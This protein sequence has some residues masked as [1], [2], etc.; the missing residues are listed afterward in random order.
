MSAGTKIRCAAVSVGLVLA[1]SVPSTAGATFPGRNGDI[2]FGLS[3][4]VK[5]PM[6]E[7]CDF[8]CMDTRIYAL[9]PQRQKVRRVPTCA[10]R[11]CDDTSPS[12]SRSG[13]YIVFERRRY[14]PSGTFDELLATANRNGTDVQTIEGGGRVPSWAPSGSR[15]AY[16]ARPAPDASSEVYIYDEREGTARRLTFGKGASPDWSAKGRIAFTRP[17]FRKGGFTGRYGLY[18]V[19]PNGRGRRLI[20]GVGTPVQPNW[21][22]SGRSLVYADLGR[23][24]TGIYRIRADGTHRRRLTGRSGYTPV[25]SPDGKRIAFNRS[26]KAIMVMNRDGSRLRRIYAPRNTGLTSPLG[27]ISW[28]VGSTSVD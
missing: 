8:T 9:D 20:T 14:T 1:V 3:R 10:L 11:E 15:F 18:S 21:S 4:Q 13:E 17:L 23:R 22:P 27:R 25:W 26:Y 12:V 7:N 24:R 6:T 5:D 19:W 28:S 2:V 16:E